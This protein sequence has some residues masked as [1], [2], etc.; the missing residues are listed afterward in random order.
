[1]GGTKCSP[2]VQERLY[3]GWSYVLKPPSIED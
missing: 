1:M 2:C 3:D